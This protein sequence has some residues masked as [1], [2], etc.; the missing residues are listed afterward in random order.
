MAGWMLLELV[1]QRRFEAENLSETG[2]V[3]Y[4]SPL[5][6]LSMSFYFHWV[7]RLAQINLKQLWA[8]LLEIMNFDSVLGGRR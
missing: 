1:M 4:D 7:G 3:S 8:V 2:L 5:S 6:G